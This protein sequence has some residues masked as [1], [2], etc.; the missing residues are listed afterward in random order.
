LAEAHASLGAVEQLLGNLAGAAESYRRARDANPHLPGV[1]RN[2]ALLA[3][4]RVQGATAPPVHD[5][6][7]QPDALP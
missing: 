4:E 1:E 2:L 7:I 5:A 3:A 6:R